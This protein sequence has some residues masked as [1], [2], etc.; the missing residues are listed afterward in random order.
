MCVC[1]YVLFRSF[2]RSKC[3]A[4]KTRRRRDRLP[5][6]EI[7]LDMDLSQPLAKAPPGVD[8]SFLSGES[9]PLYVRC[10]RFGGNRGG[11]V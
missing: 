11:V 6:G 9:P 5:D 4:P 10:A 1:A 8:L 3:F 2:E 7:W